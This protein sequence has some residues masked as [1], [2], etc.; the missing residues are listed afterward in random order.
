MH[1]QT[2][3]EFHSALQPSLALIDFNSIQKNG[4]D[5]FRTLVQKNCCWFQLNP[6]L[7]SRSWQSVR[8]RFHL[9][10][11]HTNLEKDLELLRL[12]LLGHR[13]SSRGSRIAHIFSVDGFPEFLHDFAL[14]IYKSETFLISDSV[15]RSFGSLPVI[16]QLAVHYMLNTTEETQPNSVK[17]FELLF[18]PTDARHF[19]ESCSN[20]LSIDPSLVKFFG[21]S[22][23]RKLAKN[24]NTRVENPELHE[25][26]LP[27]RIRMGKCK[28]I[29][30][31]KLSLKKRSLAQFEGLAFDSSHGGS[32]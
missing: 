6:N 24:R 13:H 15:R 29:E 8:S 1:S 10:F 2:K 31:S 3:L 20:G 30:P 27:K 4:L 11:G 22:L 32:V 19:V 21:A 18:G 12:V 5:I 14:P 26:T 16:L 9:I 17:L 28:N 25:L 23:F 7:H